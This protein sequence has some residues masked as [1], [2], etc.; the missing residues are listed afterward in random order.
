MNKGSLNIEDVDHKPTTSQKK[1]AG[2]FKNIIES[3]LFIAALIAVV[4]L[5]VFIHVLRADFVMWDDD[6]II[7][8]NPNLVGPSLRFFAD[9]DS[10]MRYNPLTLMVWSIT[11]HFFGFN[12]FWFHFGN[13]LLHGLSSGMV[14][15]VLRKLLLIGFSRQ[16]D[17]EP[18][19]LN[20]CVA[21][22][23][24]L[25]SL[26][27]LR[28]EPVAW[29]TDRTYC[30]AMFFLLTSLLFYLQA[31]EG[32]RTV[33]RHRF[34]LAASIF[35]YVVSL[36]SY[37][38]GMCFFVVLIVLDVYPLGRIG[39]SRGWFRTVEVRKV[40]FEKVPF[41]ALGIAV[42]LVSIG[43]RIA[44]AGVW[45]KPVP[46]ADFGLSERFMQAMYIW[47][48]Y[49]WRPWYP[50]KLAPVYTTLINFDPFSLPFIVSSLIV[51]ILTVALW[52]LRN[53]WPLGLALLACHL[54]L[55]VPVLGLFEHPHSPCDRYSLIVSL[56]WSVLL[57]AF[58]ANPKI[59][60]LFRSVIITISI[61]MISILGM[62][63]F[64]QTKIWNNS[65]TLFRHMIRNLGEDTY[66]HDIH[67]RLGL[68][69]SSQ[70]DTVQAIEQYQKTLEIVPDHHKTQYLMAETLMRQGKFRQAVEYYQKVLQIN[71]NMPEAHN[72]IG[73]AL[74][75]L[76][77]PDEAI[78][79]FKQSLQLNPDNS[80]VHYNLS[81]VLL[82]QNKIAKLIFHWKEV[83]RLRPDSIKV[84]NSLV[85]ILATVEDDD[86]RDPAEA[87]RFGE[88]VCKLTGYKVPEVLDTLSIAYAATGDFPKAIE[89]SEKALQLIVDNE[90]LTNDIQKRIELYKASK[91]YYNE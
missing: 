89:I 66:R 63:T 6:I 47:A 78:D 28:T 83:L 5:I 19:R 42:A 45:A 54:V 17:V 49:V 29:C 51:I 10:M 26:H 76:D 4:T 27:P 50:I 15:L 13:W 88:R 60:R 43:I 35:F 84:L 41:I 3:P 39:G 36:L 16:C 70:D 85:W 33:V 18:W 24:L 73:I 25:W 40:L 80:D 67:R 23:A 75:N 30:Q 62:L 55:L 59:G 31:N 90:E 46:L 12:P 86:L 34:I 57:A 81:I 9:V 69:Y 61:V 1:L 68:F 82:K 20:I 79:H 64:Q 48:Y 71:P 37:A 56:T 21:I 38:I 58:L 77:N 91:P 2:C 72:N 44:S 22:G 52:R 74:L 53:R 87:V 8:Q 65:A 7:Y 14:F 11:H 32:D